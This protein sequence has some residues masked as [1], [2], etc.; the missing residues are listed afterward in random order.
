MKTKSKNIIIFLSLFFVVFFESFS[1]P[2]QFTIEPNFGVR[3]GMLTEHVFAKNSITGDEYTLSLLEWDLKS[4]AYFGIDAD[5]NISNFVIDF[6]IKVFASTRVGKM[7]DFDWNQDAGYGTGNTSLKTNFSEHECSLS[8]GANLELFLKYNFDVS[9]FTIAPVIG[10]TFE[11]YKFE[12][13]NGWVKYGNTK[14]GKNV[15]YYA[16]N[17][18]ENSYSKKVYGNLVNLDRS[19][20]YTWIGVDFSAKFFQSKLSFTGKIAIAPYTIM[21]ANDE[22]VVRSN[23]FIDR[24][25]GWGSSV[26]WEVFMKYQ[27]I[28]FFGLKFGVSGLSTK[29]LHGPEYYSTSKNGKYYLLSNSTGGASTQYVDIKFSALFSW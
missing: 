28:D 10:I 11:N 3:N 17:D 14:D 16:Y 12:S 4:A 1:K 7:I 24:L 27:P 21:L 2:I 25:S 8:S 20:L 19:D 26:K 5:V 18:L 15:S 23:Y 29:V 22:H 13:H 6:G 9:Y